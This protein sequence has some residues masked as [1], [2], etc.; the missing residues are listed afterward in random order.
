MTITDQILKEADGTPNSK[1]QASDGSGS[2]TVKSAKVEQAIQE[3]T[4]E[5]PRRLATPRNFKRPYPFKFSTSQELGGTGCCCKLFTIIAI[6]LYSSI[7]PIIYF[8]GYEVVDIPQ[9]D[10]YYTLYMYLLLFNGLILFIG[11]YA[12]VGCIA[13]P[14]SNYAL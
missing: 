5:L 12:L 7:F 9:D 13:Y 2:S 3:E 1:I 14:Y 6:L 8:Y 4:D 11:G 10:S